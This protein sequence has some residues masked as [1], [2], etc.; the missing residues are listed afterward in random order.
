MSHAILSPSSAHRWIECNPSARLEE[1]YPDTSSAAADEG[2]L[3]HSLGELILRRYTHDISQIEFDYLFEAIRKSIY[4]NEDMLVHAEDYA[5]YVISFFE[6][7]K[8]KTPD[9]LLIIEAKLN[10][11]KWVPDGFGTGDA[12]IIADGTLHIIDLKFG[13][14][15]R[16][17]CENN[18]QMM[19]YAL[20]A[21]E[22]YSLMYALDTVRMTIYQPRLCN[23]SN[24][25]MSTVDL[26]KWADE[27]LKPAAQRAFNGEGEFKPGDHCRFCKVRQQCKAL[28]EEQMKITMY[29]FKDS[30]LLA[31][32]EIADILN[33]ADDFKKWISAIEEYALL[34]AINDGKRWPG[35]KLVE[36]RSIRTYADQQAVADAL[37]QA[38]YTDDSIFTRSLLGIT[39]MEKLLSKK[40]FEA[41]LSPLVIKPAGKPT[42]APVDDKRPEYNSTESAKSD[43]Q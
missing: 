33:R 25:E 19:L 9:A 24:Y 4:Y 37:R 18:K 35:Y 23:V 32:D 5:A 38:G 6:Q 36:G 13:K 31:D 30:Y 7:A 17:S 39:A 12:L 29:N 10:M 22:E 34:A 16:V 2:T 26:E 43:F 28:Y 1:N 3:A 8:T 42:L 21:L 14:G 11:S 41:M 40:T 20:G 15:V 27:E